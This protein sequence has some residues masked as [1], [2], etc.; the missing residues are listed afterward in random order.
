M[1]HCLGRPADNGMVDSGSDDVAL[2]GL[3]STTMNATS[4]LNFGLRTSVCSKYFV[5]ITAGRIQ[6]PIQVTVVNA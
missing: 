5:C 2:E 4:T 1:N 6:A 3:G